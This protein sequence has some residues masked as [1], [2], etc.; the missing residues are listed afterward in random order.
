MKVY[1][2]GPYSNTS[3]RQ[4]QINVNKAIEIGCEI[5]KKGHNPYI[6]HLTHY[7]WL[8]PNG[9]FPYEKWCELD[10]EWLKSCD[11]LFFI[12]HSNG[13]TRELELAQKLNLK[14]FY[15]LEEIN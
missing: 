10:D 2:A 3:A 4:T 15:N 11:G 8:N 6:P 9:D 14:I 13:A 7:V 1:I 12:G 5:I